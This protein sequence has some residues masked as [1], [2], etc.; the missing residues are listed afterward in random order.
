[1][2][3]WWV[4]IGVSETV[5]VMP[6]ISIVSRPWVVLVVFMFVP[7]RE[8]YEVG[9]LKSMVEKRVVGRGVYLGVLWARGVWSVAEGRGW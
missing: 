7:P 5:Q 4:A 3:F 1:M 2:G 6:M 9:S 8:Y